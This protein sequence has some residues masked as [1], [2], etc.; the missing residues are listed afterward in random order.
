MIPNNSNQD[1]GHVQDL[2]EI[3]AESGAEK[4][5]ISETSLQ[6]KSASDNGDNCVINICHE[7]VQETSENAES[8]GIVLRNSMH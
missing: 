3:T 6:S 2:D 8:E 4:R 7:I 5:E 1:H